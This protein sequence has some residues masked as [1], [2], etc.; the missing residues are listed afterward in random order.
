MSERQ[1]YYIG[2]KGII[3]DKTGRVL[4]LK[5]SSTGKWEVPGGR[6]DA[7]QTIEGAFAREIS[8]E[9]E[10]ASLVR[11]GELLCAAQGDYLV[12]NKHK[13]MLLFY[14]VEVELPPRLALSSEHTEFAWV[15]AQSL[16]AYT[17]YAS[18]K[19][20]VQKSIS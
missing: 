18:D 7:G 15:D 4:I 17:M 3:K 16:G 19:A 14:A 10:G 1:S 6:I 8:E 12:E 5:D 9:I 13:L 20:A 11:F 2:I